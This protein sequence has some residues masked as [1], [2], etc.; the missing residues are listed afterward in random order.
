MDAIEETMRIYICID[1]KWTESTTRARLPFASRLFSIIE[2][3]E[4]PHS[5]RV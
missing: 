3:P 5:R 2:I 1:L 4:L